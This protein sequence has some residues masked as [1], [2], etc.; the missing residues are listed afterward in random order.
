[1]DIQTRSHRYQSSRDTILATSREIFMRN[2]YVEASMDTI[3]QHSGV[4]KTTLYAHFDSKEALFNQ[5]VARVVEE[6]ASQE[7]DALL[8]V[9]SGQTLRQRLVTIG[10]HILERLL[11]SETSALMRL[12]VIEGAR[13]PRQT[14]D[15]LGESHRRLLA[16]LARFFRD[17]AQGEGLR[18]ENADEAADLFVVLTMRDFMLEA[19]LPW[20]EVNTTS[21]H[22]QNAERVADTILRLYGSPGG[23]AVTPL[24]RLDSA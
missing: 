2:G 9:G 15:G 21:A 5:V 11:D 24:V 16:T 13:M 12:C 6:R 4:S 8:D 10:C 14:Y 7:L 22:R 20:S 17:H 18:I 23:N 19:M 3:A 1:M